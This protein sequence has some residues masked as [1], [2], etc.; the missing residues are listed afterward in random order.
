MAARP[1]AAAP[2]RRPG[3]LDPSRPRGGLVP[4]GP[5]NRNAIDALIACHS[6]VFDLTARRAYV[7]A[8]P[9]TLGRFVCFD[10]DLLAS[11]EPGDP[12]YAALDSATIPAD[13]YFRTGGY[14]RYL[15]A[16]QANRAARQELRA[17]NLDAAKD[18]AT[19]ALEAAPGFV[20]ALAC[21]GEANIRSRHFAGARSDFDAA[22]RL[23]PGPPEFAAAIRRF[24][25][26]AAAGRIPNKPLPYP[27]SL[28]DTMGGPE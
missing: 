5:G 11:T 20:E 28:E 18:Q 4:L 3:G 1:G 25:D 19:R 12:R 21:R 9:H 6:V 26:S 23:D 8:A 2:R 22:L 7:A 17:G 27:V 15:Q 14:A 16:R 24:R 10:L 13:P